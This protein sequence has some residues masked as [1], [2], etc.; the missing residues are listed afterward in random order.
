MLLV[1]SRL[2][3]SSIQLLAPFPKCIDCSSLNEIFL[4]SFVN[5]EYLKAIFG[6]L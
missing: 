6:K 4:E 5:H 1:Y 3:E 2:H